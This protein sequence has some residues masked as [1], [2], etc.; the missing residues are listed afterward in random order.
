VLLLLISEPRSN[1][2]VRKEEE[3]GRHRLNCAISL[4]PAKQKISFIQK[5]RT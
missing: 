4:T 5:K 1:E 2:K 3:E